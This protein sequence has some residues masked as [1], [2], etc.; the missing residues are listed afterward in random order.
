MFRVE[1]AWTSAA[2]PLSIV[3]PAHNAIPPERRD[4]FVNDCESS[5]AQHAAHFIQH[6][7]RVLRVMQHVTEQH[8]VEALIAHRKM[9]AIV[10]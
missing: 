4:V 3:R 1:R 8:R 10:R 2:A 5:F 6:E 9:P 7:S